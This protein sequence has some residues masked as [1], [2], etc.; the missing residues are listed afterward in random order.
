MKIK[1]LH[2]SMAANERNFAKKEKI[3][4]LIII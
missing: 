1:W 4:V 2:K 3:T